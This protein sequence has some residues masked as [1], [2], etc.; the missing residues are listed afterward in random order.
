MD[1]ENKPRG[2]YPVITDEDVY[3]EAQW[4]IG[5]LH[6]LNNTTVEEELA[7]DVLLQLKL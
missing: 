3:W 4:A 2:K 7:L 6:N 5:E 1:L